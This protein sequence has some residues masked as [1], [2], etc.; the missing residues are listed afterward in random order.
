MSAS[1]SLAG[2]GRKGGTESAFGAKREGPTL[3]TPTTGGR[4]AVVTVDDGAEGDRIAGA[5][6][7]GSVG[8]TAT[9]PE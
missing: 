2:A 6:R 8:A 1:T 9:E 7:R 3:A 4:A 5:S